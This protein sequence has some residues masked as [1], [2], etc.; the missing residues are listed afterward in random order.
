MGVAVVRDG[1]KYELVLVGPAAVEHRD[2][3]VGSRGGRL[4]CQVGVAD[5]D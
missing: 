3:G 1:G 5:L 2:P 4:H